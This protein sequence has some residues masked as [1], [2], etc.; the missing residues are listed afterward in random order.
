MPRYLDQLHLYASVIKNVGLQFNTALVFIELNDMG[1]AVANI[2]HD[3]FEYENLLFTKME[4][5]SLKPVLFGG[6]ADNKGIK[7][8]KLTKRNGCLSLKLI[9]GQHQV[10][11]NDFETINELGTFVVKGNSW[12]AEEGKHDDLAMGLVLFSWLA[13]SKH[14]SDFNDINTIKSMKES[15]EE[16]LHQ[17]NTPFGFMNDGREEPKNADIPLLSVSDFDRLLMTWDD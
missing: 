17:L 1:E 16:T 12:Q 3:D 10:T 2:L 6:S 11:I 14:F 5:K 8:T 9:A 7:T 15:S 13:S 4:K